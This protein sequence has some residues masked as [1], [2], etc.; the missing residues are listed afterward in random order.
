ML[1]PTAITH[2]TTRPSR[3]PR[4]AGG[5][6]LLR[7]VSAKGLASAAPR[8]PALAAHREEVSP[9]ATIAGERERRSLLCRSPSR[10]GVDENYP[11]V[12]AKG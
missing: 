12:S 1:T 6:R 4:T 2:S 5:F 7:P 9:P 3:S 11:S 10:H 8:L